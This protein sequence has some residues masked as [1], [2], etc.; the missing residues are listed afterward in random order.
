MIQFASRRK[1]RG[2]YPS[3][4]LDAIGETVAGVKKLDYSHITNSLGELPYLDFKTFSFYNVMDVIVQK[5]IEVCTQDLEYVFTKCLAKILF[6]LNK[7][8]CVSAK[9]IRKGLL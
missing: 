7:D 4:K 1:G 6:I 2:R 8:V 9:Q 5:C 3:F